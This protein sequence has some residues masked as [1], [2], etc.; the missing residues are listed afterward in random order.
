[1]KIRDQH[2]HRQPLVQIVMLPSGALSW[3]CHGLAV[4]R[5]PADP[6]GGMQAV[7]V[8]TGA[9]W[10]GKPSVAE[11]IAN[12]YADAARSRGA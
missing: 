9:A 4:T 5:G 11:M 7:K 8:V 6:D 3:V 12:R 1:M 2:L 10:H